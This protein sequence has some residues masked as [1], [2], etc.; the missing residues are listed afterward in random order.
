MRS[1]ERALRTSVCVDERNPAEG[2]KFLRD[3][4][5]ADLQATAEIR[6][7]KAAANLAEAEFYEGIAK[8][9]EHAGVDAVGDL[10]RDTLEA[11]LSR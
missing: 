6:R 5:A 1:T 11:V 7:R 2:W 9:I 10:P 4:T 8:A 3:C